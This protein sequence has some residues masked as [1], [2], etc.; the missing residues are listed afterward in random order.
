MI[1]LVIWIIFFIVGYLI[2]YF[3]ADVFLDNMKEICIIYG[4]SPFI[5]GVLIVGIDPEESIASIIA[6]V[7]GLSYIAIGNVI[8]NSIIAL[9]VSFSIPA[10]FYKIQIKSIPQ[11]YFLLLYTCMLLLLLGFFFNYG[12]IIIGIS[13][14]CIYFTY[15]IRNLSVLSN[16]SKI[17]SISKESTLESDSE[18]I[19][20]QKKQNIKKFANIF[21]SFMFIILGGELLIFSTEQMLI[22]TNIPE[23][24]FGFVIIAFVTNVEELT[25]VFKSIKKKSMEIGLGGMI[26]KVFWN[27]SLTF[28]VSAIIIMNL[29]ISWFLFWNWFALLVIIFY[30]NWRSQKQSLYWQDGI[31]LLFIF[32][33]FLMINFILV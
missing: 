24:V 5:I 20:S 21:I 27:L 9:T 26:G 13:A 25:L 10:L 18:Y 16:Q 7:N 2:I 29:S 14:I 11:M 8:G 4:I 19:P 12:L 32:T 33:I 28:G 3:A 23:T 22:L 1:A 6:A 15:L 17:L 31:L 30:L